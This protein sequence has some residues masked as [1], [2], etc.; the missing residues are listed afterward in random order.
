MTN[1]RR[2]ILSRNLHVWRKCLELSEVL[3][4]L[5]KVNVI[6][7][8]LADFIKC[9]GDV[10]EGRCELL[11]Q[12]ERRGNK[13]FVHFYNALNYSG[14]KKLAQ[15]LA[16]EVTDEEKEEGLKLF[17]VA[18]NCEALR[19]VNGNGVFEFTRLKCQRRED[20]NQ[21][22]DK[23]S[24][25]FG[26]PSTSA[27]QT[28]QNPIFEPRG[29]LEDLVVEMIDSNVIND[30]NSMVFDEQKVYKNFSSPRGLV[31]IINNRKFMQM[32][33]RVGTDID[34]SNLKNLFNQLG[35]IVCVSKDLTAKGMLQS[36]HKFSMRAEH[37]VFDS[38][39]VCVLTHGENNELFGI[40]DEALSVHEFMS[41]LNGL[42]CPA[43]LHKPK[44]FILQ[45]CRGQRYD[46]GVRITGDATDAFVGNCFGF[47]SPKP[48]SCNTDV[49]NKLPAEAD[50]LIAYATV[51]GYVSW[52]NNI[53][54]S[55][56]I[57]S[58]CEIFAKY[59]KEMDILEMLTL[60]NKRVSEVYESS[61]DS[62][63]QIPECATRL[64]RKFYF[65]P[66]LSFP[67][68]NSISC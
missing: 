51:P 27:E 68:S 29:I 65:F 11:R 21:R 63:K 22:F 19:E 30:V 62:Y 59:A 28:F 45:A 33:E 67:V 16:D 36:I 13:A 4:Y 12:L 10:Q 56:F 60:V 55:W 46:P 48:G 42:N 25:F 7:D 66:G 41:K 1:K 26:Q 43:L 49:S 3:L 57:Q 40:D 50:F 58:I 9:K 35:Y 5:Q 34:E 15:L 23:F 61:R 39:V 17:L 32:T 31:L 37:K 54:G 53:R 8:G 18:N 44:I 14:Q 2:Q 64:R 47:T 20:F 24:T 52:R 38:C 6:D